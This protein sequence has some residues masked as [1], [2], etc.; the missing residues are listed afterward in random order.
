MVLGHLVLATFQGGT[1]S[2]KATLTGPIGRAQDPWPLWPF[3]CCL[4]ACEASQRLTCLSPSALLPNHSGAPWAQKLSRGFAASRMS[5]WGPGI[6]QLTW[7]FYHACCTLPLQQSA[8]EMGC[9]TPSQGPL[10]ASKLWMTH[11]C[12]FLTC[13]LSSAFWVGNGSCVSTCFH[14]E[15]RVTPVPGSVTGPRYS[16]WLERVKSGST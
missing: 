16:T 5:S 12:L 14:S 15:G 6:L 10:P 8:Q 11:N 7:D 13:R 1:L 9:W 4:V 2:C 3:P